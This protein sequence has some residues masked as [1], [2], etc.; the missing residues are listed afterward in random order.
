MIH[1]PA[2]TALRLFIMRRSLGA[3]GALIVVLMALAALLANWL[4]PYDPL[5]NDFSA[6]LQQLSPHCACSL[7][8]APW[9]P[10]AR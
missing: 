8:G 6:M 7:R 9:A 3:A 1:N 5:E 4:A 2:A 10:P